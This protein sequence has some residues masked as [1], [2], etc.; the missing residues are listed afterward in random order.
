[1]A[2]KFCR[3]LSRNPTSC[4]ED[5]DMDEDAP[6]EDEED[7][8]ALGPA[9]LYWNGLSCFLVYFFVVHLCGFVV[10]FSDTFLWLNVYLCF[11]FALACNLAPRIPFSV[12][13]ANEVDVTD[14]LFVAN[15]CL[16]F[17]C[18]PTQ[19]MFVTDF[20]WNFVWTYY[21]AILTAISA[22]LVLIV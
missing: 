10:V 16:L 5:D 14:A 9:R 7:Q 20:F 8:V 6:F 22:M 2:R 12:G 21:S 15:L 18:V 19:K 11:L 3:S 4:R 1:M 13:L 17:I